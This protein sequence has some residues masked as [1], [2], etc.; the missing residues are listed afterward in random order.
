MRKLPCVTDRGE[1]RRGELER[2][3]TVVQ[4]PNNN[5]S[6]LM[7]MRTGMTQWMGSASD[8]IAKVSFRDMVLGLLILIDDGAKLSNSVVAHLLGRSIGYTALLNRIKALWNPKG[9]IILIDLDNNYYL[10][11][12]A[13]V[14]DCLKVIMGDL[15]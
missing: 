13:L 7:R 10:I 12:F 6:G 3:G 15:G 14:E 11:R 8:P 5:L 4:V 2:D 1:E 9:T